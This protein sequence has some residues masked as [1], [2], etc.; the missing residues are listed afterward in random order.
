M[1]GDYEDLVHGEGIY[2]QGIDTK[3]ISSEMQLE[4]IERAFVGINDIFASMSKEEQAAL[5]DRMRKISPDL[6][7]SVAFS[8]V[9]D[10][11]N[12]IEEIL[13]QY[14]QSDA[15]SKIARE[16]GTVLKALFGEHGYYS[17][18]TINPETES[19]DFLLDI[20]PSFQS[21]DVEY[22]NNSLGA[23]MLGARYKESYDSKIIKRKEMLFDQD[24]IIYDLVGNRYVCQNNDVY[25]KTI[26]Y[27]VNYKKR[28]QGKDNSRAFSIDNIELHTADQAILSKYFQYGCDDQ[29]GGPVNGGEYKFKTRRA[30]DGK[31][32]YVPKPEYEGIIRAVVAERGRNAL[33]LDCS[34]KYY[35]NNTRQLETLHNETQIIPNMSTFLIDEYITHDPYK[36]RGVFANFSRDFIRES[37]NQ[38]IA[39]GRDYAQ[40]FADVLGEEEFIKNFKYIK[41]RVDNRMKLAVYIVTHEIPLDVLEPVSDIEDS[42]KIYG[43]GNGANGGSGTYKI[44]PD[45]VR[46]KGSKLGMDIEDIDSIFVYDENRIYFKRNFISQIFSPFQAE[47][48]SKILCKLGKDRRDEGFRIPHSQNRGK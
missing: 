40:S 47:D 2:A 8:T 3:G 45:Q 34:T 13:T 38:I 25:G 20:Y 9:R 15:I 44:N 6:M 11:K 30:E 35:N 16:E 19:F 29:T 43:R 18:Y 4:F 21:K 27:L 14:K 32:Y 46:E 17:A 33:H 48:K 5:I 26:D 28:N 12:Q 1:T 41:H 39:L 22:L 10:R 7:Q 23:N 37:K 31:E 42:V 24:E 36:S